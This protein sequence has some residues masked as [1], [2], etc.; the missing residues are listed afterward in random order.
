[1]LQSGGILPGFLT[2]GRGKGFSA[3]MFFEKYINLVLG[4]PFTVLLSVFLLT[5]FLGWN[6]QQ[7]RMD[8][9][10]DSL[11]VEGD[12][13]LEY[14]RVINSRYGAGDFVFVTYAP[15]L[16][17]FTPPLTYATQGLEERAGADYQC[18]IC[19]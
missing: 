3:I 5:L 15:N 4:K 17:L 2:R 7:F 11:V 18:G 13:D 8:A 6:A 1:M 12:A 19:G 9:S 16:G 14:S 10:A